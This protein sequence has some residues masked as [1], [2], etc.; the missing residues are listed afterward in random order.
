MKKDIKN[1]IGDDENGAMY[2]AKT[3]WIMWAITI[4]LIIVLTYLAA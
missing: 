1:Y 3:P 4:V 2:A